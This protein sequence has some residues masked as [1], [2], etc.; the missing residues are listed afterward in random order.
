VAAT[1]KHPTLGP[2]AFEGMGWTKVV[3]VPA[4]KACSYD[5]G[6][7]NAPRSTGKHRLTFATFGESDVP[8]PA[9]V[10]LADRLLANQAPLVDAIATALWEDFNGRGSESGMWWH[11]DLATAAKSW[12]GL[13]LP[14]PAKPADVLPGLQLGRIIVRDGFP[15][16]PAD[17]II[18]LAFHAAFEEEH[19]VSIL[20]DGQSILGVGYNLDVMPYDYT[21]SITRRFG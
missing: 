21:P 14:P 17:P 1:W 9:K 5:T 19:G 11:G 2:F 15:R 3:D 12:K 16:H 7:S 8:S 10:A 18:E 13:K 6:Y 4:F 20:T